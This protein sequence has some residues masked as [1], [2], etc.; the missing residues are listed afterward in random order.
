MADEKKLS[1]LDHVKL[2]LRRFFGAGQGHEAI[3][4][5]EKFVFEIANELINSKV[6]GIAQ[7]IVSA[8]EGYAEGKAES[9]T[10][11]ALSGLTPAPSAGSTVTAAPSAPTDNAPVKV[12]V[13]PESFRATFDTMPADAK[14]A[15]VAAH[16]S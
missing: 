9:A 16:A 11:A 13:I 14:R 4:L 7:P 8:I 2:E 10:D 3:S 15:Y 12:V 1:T 5:L 6:P